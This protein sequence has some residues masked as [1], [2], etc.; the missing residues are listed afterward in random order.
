MQGGGGVFFISSYIT[1]FKIN[2]LQPSKNNCWLQ[3]EN[4]IREEQIWIIV[5]SKDINLFGYGWNWACTTPTLLSR[6][7]LWWNSSVTT[8]QIV[9]CM[10]TYLFIVLSD[11][12]FKLSYNYMY[13]DL[14]LIY[15]SKNLKRKSYM[16][17]ICRL[18]IIISFWQDDVS[19]WH[20]NIKILTNQHQLSRKKNLVKWLCFLLDTEITCQ[21]YQN[22][23]KDGDT[24]SLINKSTIRYLYCLVRPLCCLVRSLCCLD[25]SLCCLVRSLCRIVRY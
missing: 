17:I 24:D 21:I 19:I 12:Y 5:K 23:Q 25:R 15:V 14:L 10:P 9:T 2:A 1:Y 3:I 18:V 20:E 6:R 22:W 13:V 11:Y 16:P 4:T 7:I 8:C